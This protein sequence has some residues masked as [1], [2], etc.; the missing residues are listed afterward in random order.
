[1]FKTFFFQLDYTEVANAEDA[2]VAVD[3]SPVTVRVDL[4]ALSLYLAADH[5]APKRVLVKSNISG[6]RQILL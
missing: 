3:D 2:D 1:M 5:I 4:R 6:F